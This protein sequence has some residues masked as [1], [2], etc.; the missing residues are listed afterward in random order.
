[1]A[2]RGTLSINEAGIKGTS[3]IIP[4]RIYFRIGDVAGIVGVKPFVLRFWEKEFTFLSPMKNSSGQR[5]YQRKDIESALLIKRL[6]YKDRYSIE[7]A[8]NRIRELR[9]EKVLGSAKDV[10]GEWNEVHLMALQR[11]RRGLCELLKMTAPY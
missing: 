4:E 11:I 10:R 5:L 6:L 1:M 2:S 7:G 9:K 8:K 3:V